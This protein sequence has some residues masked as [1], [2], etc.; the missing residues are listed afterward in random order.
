M[1]EIDTKYFGRI[2]LDAGSVIEFP[3]GLPAFEWERAFLAIEHPR[4]A[5]LVM[6]QSVLTPELCFLAIPVA[7]VDPEYELRVCTEDR[8]ALG[9]DETSDLPT[10]PDLAV[11]AL[12]AVRADQQITVNLMSPVVVNRANRR[13]VQSVRWDGEYSHEYSIT[14]LPAR[15][16]VLGQ[17]CW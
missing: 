4:T 2:T 13:A 6:L 16:S 15:S 14:G 10:G 1:S 5:P 9:L 17:S 3:Q 8:V 11:L 12:V 7:D